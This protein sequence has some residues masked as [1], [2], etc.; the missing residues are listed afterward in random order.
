MSLQWE[1]FAQD[2]LNGLDTMIK[3]LL[4]KG[5]EQ[6]VKKY[7]YYRV[8]VQ[9]EMEERTSQRRAMI[10]EERTLQ[11]RAMMDEERTSQ[12]RAMMDEERT[13]QRRAMMDEERTSQRRAMM[14][15]ERTS[16]RRAMMDEERTSQRRAMMDEER[17][18]QRRAM[19]DEERTSQRRAMMDEERTSQRRAMMDEE[20]TSQRRAMMDEERTS[21]RRAMMDEERTSQ[22]RATVEPTVEMGYQPPLPLPV[23]Y[24]QSFPQ[25]HHQPQPL[26]HEYMLA[27]PSYSLDN[28]HSNQRP[29]YY[30]PSCLPPCYPNFYVVEPEAT[31]S[32]SRV[33]ETYV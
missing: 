31:M 8:A 7:D 11:R 6:I 4:K 3:R 21:Q 17:T 33:P 25:Y 29:P 20:R 30:H 1:M 28:Y 9:Q 12:R 32:K 22:R 27:K 18:S 26:D 19:M 14:D 24:N 23:P 10:D 13:S 15:E 5:L 16:Q 2:D